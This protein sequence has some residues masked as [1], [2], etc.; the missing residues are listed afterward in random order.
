MECI[1]QVL[2]QNPSHRVLACA[3]SNE[4]ADLICSRL[5]EFKGPDKLFRLNAFMRN[6]RSIEPDLMWYSKY[7]DGSFQIPDVSELMGY[8]IIVSTCSSSGYLFR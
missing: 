1:L 7:C 5:A 2:H 4:A 3:P 8:Q 6:P